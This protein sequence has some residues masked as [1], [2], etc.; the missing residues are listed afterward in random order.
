MLNE[1]VFI[2]RRQLQR[3]PV[4][5]EGEQPKNKKRRQRNKNPPT[6]TLQNFTWIW[7]KF[8]VYT[9]FIYKSRNHG[10]AKKKKKKREKTPLDT[11]EVLAKSIYRY[12]FFLVNFNHKQMQYRLHWKKKTSYITTW[13]RRTVSRFMQEQKSH[14]TVVLATEYAKVKHTHCVW[15]FRTASGWGGEVSLS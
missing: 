7:S 10:R 6:L 2:I 5:L 13:G 15:P 3:K 4:K 1:C 12:V 8:I 11:A 9:G 14:H